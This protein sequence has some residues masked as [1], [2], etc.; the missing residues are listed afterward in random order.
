MDCRARSTP[1]L[2]ATPLATAPLA[3]GV[4]TFGV[5]VRRGT[6]LRNTNASCSAA[7]AIGSRRAS[8]NSS[9]APACLRDCAQSSAVFPVLSRM[10]AWAWAA[11]RIFMQDVMPRYAAPIKGVKPCT[12]AASTAAPNLKTSSRR[13]ASLPS[14]AAE[15]TGVTPPRFA[16][17]QSAPYSPHNS[18][19]TSAWSFCAAMSTGV[20]PSPA[21][22]VM[23]APAAYNT[24][25]IRACPSAAAT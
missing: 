25:R 5:S 20:A 16:V 4:V 17:L 6:K 9:T 12:F 22:S 23:E 18:S 21:G 2:T 3:C 1:F 14:V 7:M 24:S 15:N 11:M 13:Q 19:S 8:C 10:P